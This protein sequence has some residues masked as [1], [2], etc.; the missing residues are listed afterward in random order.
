V[1]CVD[2]DD[3]LSLVNDAIRAIDGVKD[4]EV[5]TYLRMVKQWQPEF[6]RPSRGDLDIS[7]GED[8]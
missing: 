4:V 3:L 1:V 7:F 8:V 2:S 5:I 6:L